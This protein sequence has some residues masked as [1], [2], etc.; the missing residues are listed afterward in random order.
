MATTE[1]RLIRLEAVYE[2]LATKEDIANVRAE[3]AG[4]RGDLR[5]EIASM[6]NRVMLVLG[7]FGLVGFAALGILVALD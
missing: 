5:G 4:L 1:E 6:G 7:S 2:H 3:I